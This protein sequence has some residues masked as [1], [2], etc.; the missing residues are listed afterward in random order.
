MVDL[1]LHLGDLKLHT[2]DLELHVENL[3]LQL[4]DLELHLG[5]LELHTV[6]LHELYIGI[7]SREPVVSLNC[8]DGHSQESCSK[9]LE[10]AF[11]N[12]DSMLVQVGVGWGYPRFR[13]RDSKQAKPLCMALCG[14]RMRLAQVSQVCLR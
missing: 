12:G 5:E 4:V 2:V 8:M 7:K 11:C 13:R 1:E 6:D 14:I 10:T 3:E 9:V